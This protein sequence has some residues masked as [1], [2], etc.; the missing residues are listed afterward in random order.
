MTQRLVLTIAQART[1]QRS[2]VPWPA[3]W[4]FMLTEEREKPDTKPDDDRMAIGLTMMTMGCGD[5][6]IAEHLT[7][8]NNSTPLKQLARMMRL[9]SRR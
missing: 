9:M 2:T 1:L 5:D 8:R 6:Q 7:W 4:S 3:Q